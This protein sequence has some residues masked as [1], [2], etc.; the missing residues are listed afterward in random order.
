MANAR[1]ASEFGRELLRG[2]RLRPSYVEFIQMSPEAL[3]I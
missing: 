3:I 2:S 1:L